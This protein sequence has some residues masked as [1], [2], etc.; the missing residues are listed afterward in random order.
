M[1][2][3]NSH[4]ERTR[5]QNSNSENNAKVKQQ[6]V[7]KCT[8]KNAIARNR[9]KNARAEQ[10][11]QGNTKTE[12]QEREGYERGMLAARK[13]ESKTAAGKGMRKQSGSSASAKAAK[14]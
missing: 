2:E 6:H 12:K 4:Y 11:E 8:S 13:C 9:I 14:H 3:Q 1:P 10:Q 5:F 7:Q